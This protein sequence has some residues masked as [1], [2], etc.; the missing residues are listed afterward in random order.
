PL[1]NRYQQDQRKAASRLP[2][3]KPAPAVAGPHAVWPL[4]A[5]QQP[6]R[7]AKLSGRRPP[8]SPGG[9][10]KEVVTICALALLRPA[11]R[12]L[13]MTCPAKTAAASPVPRW[14]SFVRW[15]QTS[16]GEASQAEA[17]L[18][19]RCKSNYQVVDTQLSG[20]K[21]NFIHSIV[22]GDV[23]KP[24]LVC[25]PGFGA[26]I[27][28]F[29]RNIDHWA[30]HFHTYAVDWL[31]TG[32][33]GRPDFNVKGR[34]EAEDFFVSSLASWQEKI[35]QKKVILMGHSL[36]GYLAATYALKHPEHVEHLILVC[37]AAI[38]GRPPEDDSP[39]SVRSPWTLR[40]QL[41]RFSKLMWNVGVT[42]QSIVRLMGPWGPDLVGKYVV[43]RFNGFITDPEEARDLQE[44][45][46]QITAAKGS[47]EYA[48]RH[49]M[50]PF[51][52][53]QH[54]LEDRLADLRVPVTFIYGEEDWMDPAAA[55][56]ALK[57]LREKQGPP[58]VASDQH[59]A[60]VPNAGHFVFIDQP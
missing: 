38:A 29:Y 19:R 39:Q 33:S 18:L 48:L 46:Y 12:A 55:E 30:R 13:S 52:W 49:I 24:T 22:A 47:G 5:R 11:L 51:A 15:K 32:L 25:L 34:E 37:P 44:Y 42:P 23:A 36:G 56:R 31:G 9:F 1:A 53:A 7:K 20:G 28:F 3:T 59:I 14:A 21:Q 43:G 2:D 60:F 27:G 35:G 8:E 57:L 17:N 54:P 40:G 50:A 16:A 10:L 41:W 26:G 6:Q 4:L 45:F 58:K